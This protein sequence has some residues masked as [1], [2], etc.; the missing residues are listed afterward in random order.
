MHIVQNLVEIMAIILL[1]VLAVGAMVLRHGTRRN[2]PKWPRYQDF[3]SECG[4]NVPRTKS[5]CDRRV[6]DSDLSNAIPTT[7]GPKRT[8]NEE[9]K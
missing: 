6:F 8:N 7:F 3:C 9:V 2:R 4:N 1:V 5:D